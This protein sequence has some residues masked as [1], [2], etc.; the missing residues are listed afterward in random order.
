MFFDVF[1]TNDI[2]AYIVDNDD[3]GYK[4][5]VPAVGYERNEMDL[6]VIDN[7]L[8]VKSKDSKE[9]MG[10]FN[11]YVKLKNNIDQDN[12]DAILKNGKLSIILPEKKNSKYIKQI[13]IK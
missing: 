13:K 1:T 3:N 6:Q 11:F 8:Y 7:R 10:T 2:N 4:V 9:G 12:I 5:V